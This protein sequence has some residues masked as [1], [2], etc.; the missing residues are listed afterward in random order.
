MQGGEKRKKYRR[1][2]SGSDHVALYFC[3]TNHR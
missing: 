2:E 3:R 1:T